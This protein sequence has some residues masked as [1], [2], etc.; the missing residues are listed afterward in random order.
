MDPFELFDAILGPINPIS[1]ILGGL[2][3]IRHANYK[4][5]AD[6]NGVAG[7]LGEVVGGATGITG[8]QFTIP[9][10]GAHSLEEVQALLRRYG[11][12][13]FTILHDHENFYFSVKRSQARWAEYVLMSAGVELLN[14]PFDQ[15][16]VVSTSSQA[17]G[18]MPTPWSEKTDR[19]K[20]RVQSGSEESTDAR[21]SR[22]RTN[23]LEGMIDRAESLLVGE[24]RRENTANQTLPQSSKVDRTRSHRG[25][26]DQLDALLDR[27]LGNQ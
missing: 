3:A 6:K 1:R 20:K 24:H 18:Y 12:P 4:R 19:R 9:R 7:V 11:V 17:P 13:S 26:L 23:D 25:W 2:S 5:A 15:A 27:L 10:E 14:Q 21:K 16:N 8:F 22:P